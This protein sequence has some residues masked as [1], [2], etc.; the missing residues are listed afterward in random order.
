MTGDAFDR[1]ES[2][3]EDE[4][5]HRVDQELIAQLRAQHQHEAELDALQRA[6][7]ISDRRVLEELQASQITPA[8]LTAFSMFPSVFVAW[9]DGHMESAE[10]DAIR[11]AAK[12]QGVFSSSPGSELLESWLRHQPHAEL[13]AAWKDFIHAMRPTVSD[14]AFREIRDTAIDRAREV[15][16]A[17]GGFLGLGS[18]SAAEQSALAELKAIFDHAQDSAQAAESTT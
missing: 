10:R 2:A 12:H 14:H 7:G 6:T 3:L 9:A 16:A 15:A 13:T 4:F 5:F 8:T 1:R 18:I 11:R 17:A